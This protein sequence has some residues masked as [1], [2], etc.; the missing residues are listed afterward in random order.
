VRPTEL[1]IPMT[2]N[3]EGVILMQIAATMV[4]MNPEVAE[5]EGVAEEEEVEE[6]E[7]EGDLSRTTGV[8]VAMEVG[9]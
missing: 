8:A 4:A 1:A 9:F 5:E 2:T 6:V 3:H 7:E